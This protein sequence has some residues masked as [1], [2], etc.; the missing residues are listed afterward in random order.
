[1]TTRTMKELAGGVVLGAGLAAFVYPAYLRERCLNW[2][3]T[4]VEV[5]R[6]MPG[7]DLL[8][9]A[10][11]V[12][13]RAITIAA[14]PSAIWPWL[15]QLGPGR[16]GAYTYDWIENLL[17]LDMHSA[18][19]ILPEFQDLKPGDTVPLGPGGVPIRVEIL[20][21]ER[22]MV[23]RSEDG[24]WVWAF[25]L[26]REG[27]GITRLISR[28]RIAYPGRKLPYR[29]FVR[30]VMEP[31]SLVME[32]KMLLGIKARAEKLA[33]SGTHDQLRGQE[34]AEA[35]PYVA[36]PEVHEELPGIGERA[37]LLGK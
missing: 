24:N 21:T 14:P 19:E 28:N 1:M 12:S 27:A 20:D 36:G 6:E 9:P 23:L 13:T 33:Q 32:R 25:G 2:G 22:A 37:K 3:A 8:Q 10:P 17:R 26:Y 5:W 30:Y 34:A 29:A 7:D 15:V 18:N 35:R 16:G 4:P 31:G 11:V